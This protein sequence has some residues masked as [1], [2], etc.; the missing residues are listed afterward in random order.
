MNKYIID[1]GVYGLMVTEIALA[2][3]VKNPYA[4]N[5]DTDSITVSTSLG[6]LGGES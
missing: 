4:I 2:K 3:N 5:F 6:W 1:L